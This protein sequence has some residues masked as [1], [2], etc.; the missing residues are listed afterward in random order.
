MVDRLPR[1]P[2]LI[3]VDLVI[4]AVILTLLAAPSAV[5]IY[6]V[7]LV[8][9]L[10][11]VLLDAGETALLPAALP[12][13]LLGD[14][15]GWRSSAQEGAKLLAPLAGAALYAWRGPHA[16][17]LLCA[18]LPLATATMYALVRPQS[19]PADAPPDHPQPLPAG[20]P[21]PGVPDHSQPL[22]ADA[23]RPEVP[24]RRVTLGWSSVR[25]GIAALWREPIR[26]PVRIAGVAIAVSGMT[27]AAVLLHLVSGLHR[28][29]TDL[30]FL[31]SA[32]G[33][34]SIAG[35]LLVGRL[36][37]RLSA[38]RVAALGAGLFGVACVAWSLPWFPAMITGSV[39]AGLGLPWTL[40]AGITAIQTGT[41][42]HLLGRVAATGNL[43]MFGPI[44]LAIPIG[45]ALS[46]LGARPPL[47]LGA[48]LVGAVALLATRAT[49][50]SLSGSRGRPGGAA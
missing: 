41:P 19:L 45:A 50:R 32:Q 4:S 47:L 39:L 12:P 46:G 24:D 1:R 20:A 37:A 11:Y 44:T 16:V 25:A 22:P 3:T 28:P 6:P 35:G 7:L 27:T 33:A 13:G 29:A 43:V 5:W 17:V 9:G 10:S 18:V 26:T 31:S 40:I 2:L 38:A 42:E 14:V 48:G 34:G 8:R 30:G 15:N 23:P 21:R 36:L 49:G